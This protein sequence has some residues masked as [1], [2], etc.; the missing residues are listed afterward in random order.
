MKVPWLQSYSCVNVI[1]F[2]SPFLFLCPITWAAFRHALT[3]SWN[4]PE[5]LHVRTQMSKSVARDVFQ[6]LFPPAPLVKCPENVRVSPCE[7]TAGHYR[8]QLAATGRVDEVSNTRQKQNWKNT[9]ISGWK[10][11]HRPKCELGNIT[12]FKSFLVMRAN[13][14]IRKQVE[15]MAKKLLVIYTSCP[16]SYMLYPDATNVDSLL[17][18]SSCERQTPVN[19]RAQFSEYLPDFLSDN[20]WIH[21]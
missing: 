6:E 13:P 12:R 9:N 4:F 5:R 15:L 3:F 7:N 2:Y 21:F 17:L 8:E 16:V 14:E 11:R 19:A 1:C 20:G 10:R 18:P